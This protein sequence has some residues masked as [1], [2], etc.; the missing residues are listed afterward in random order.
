MEAPARRGAGRRRRV[1]DRAVARA[2]R[3]WSSAGDPD[4][5][6]TAMTAPPPARPGLMALYAFNLEIARAP[7]VTSEAMLAEIRLRWWLDAIGEIYD[8]AAP[9]RHEVVA[10]LAEVIRGVGPAAA[11]VRGDDRGA[12]RPTPRRGRMPT[13]RR[14][15]ST[16]AHTAG[17]LMELAARHL[18]RRGGA[19]GGA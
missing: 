12:A 2:A 7:W 1:T 5:W 8:G 17:H 18:G 6:R 15:S 16:S 4:R 19:A 3:R 10:P 14:S 13:G 11:A 9:R